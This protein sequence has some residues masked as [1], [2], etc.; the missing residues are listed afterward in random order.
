MKYYTLVLFMLG[1]CASQLAMADTASAQERGFAQGFNDVFSQCRAHFYEDNAPLL[2]GTRG[3]K[4]NKQLDA[5]CFE[6]FAVLHS[7]VSRTPIWSAAHLTRERVK[8]ARSLVRS[9]SFR[10]ESRLPHGRRA[11]LADYSQ[12]GFDRGHLSPNGDMPDAH[13]QY[14][15][16]SLANIAPQN[17]N[18]NR[19][20]WRHI[21]V[22]TRNL[23]LKHGEVYVVTG[24]AFEGRAVSR[25][26]GRVLVPSHFFKAVYIPGLNKAGVYYSAN[27]ENASYEVISLAQ[28]TARTGINAMPTLPTSVQ[29][30]A[31]SL[32]KPSADG[33]SE[34]HEIT[35]DMD[36]V[37]LSSLS[38]WLLLLLEIFK[39][40]IATLNR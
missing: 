12:S 24:V 3:Q 39:Y 5:L 32:P 23:T 33:K 27:A 40:F 8:Q 15:S 37:D 11:E 2:V 36:K 25:I 31:Y 13:T 35:F 17:G 20:I 26:G 21:E 29:N 14:E 10:S 18:H 19:N 4:L 6:G 34:N 16:F 9:D 7:G 28:L 38:G 22:A 1:L 30:H